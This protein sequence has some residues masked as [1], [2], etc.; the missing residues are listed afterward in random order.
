MKIH[1]I[2]DIITN[3]STELFVVDSDKFSKD[4]VL[5]ELT[6]MVGEFGMKYFTIEEA[7][8]GFL[9]DYVEETFN[10]KDGDI[11]VTIKDNL[12]PYDYS[13]LIAIEEELEAERYHLG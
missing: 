1:S 6:R 10:C 5:Q 3:S 4:K 12:F 2:I 13:D 9:P 8:G 7:P 11:L